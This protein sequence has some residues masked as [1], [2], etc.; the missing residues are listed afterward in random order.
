MASAPISDPKPPK[1]RRRAEC[2]P[3]ELRKEITG[4]S[5]GLSR[6]YRR[7]F[8]RDRKLKDRVLTLLRATLPP[9]PRRPGHPRD[10]ETTKAAL[11]HSQFRR[12][13]PKAR[14]ADLLGMVCAA[15]HPEYANLGP[16]AQGDM[17]AGLRERL[18]S[19]WR[20]RVRNS[21]R[22]KSR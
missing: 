22:R 2:I 20:K 19:R 17:R 14:P 18:R 8:A 10:P 1:G 21:A 9:R 4:I 13:H 6:K 16:I 5:R 12:Q 3:K 11:L 15:L 7:D